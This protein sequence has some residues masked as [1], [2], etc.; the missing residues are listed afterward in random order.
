MS[1]SHSRAK[2][3]NELVS[4]G[5]KDD[6]RMLVQ[7]EEYDINGRD[8]YGVGVVMKAVMRNDYEMLEMLI[9]L[10]AKVNVKW[11]TGESAYEC[12]KGKGYDSI[13]N[14]IKKNLDKS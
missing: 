3:L 11:L 5:Q 7:G 14:L 13:A 6:V 8:K 9:D 1:D 4:L 12:A 10:G 2:L